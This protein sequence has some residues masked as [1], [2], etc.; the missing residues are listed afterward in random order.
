MIIKQLSNTQSNSLVI[1][2]NSLNITHVNNVSRTITINQQPALF[3][4]YIVSSKLSISQS[5]PNVVSIIS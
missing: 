3:S 2:L 1:S 5:L 4:A